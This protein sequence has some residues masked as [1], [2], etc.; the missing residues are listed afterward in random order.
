MDTSM[1]KMQRKLYIKLYDRM[2]KD[3]VNEII[4]GNIILDPDYQRN[5][6]WNNNK[7]SLLIESVLLNIPI[8][9]IYA[10][11]DSSDKW[12][13]VD[14]LQRLYS[15]Q[16]YFNN[17][18]KLVGLETLPELNGLKF[19]KLDESIQKR[20][21][22]GE[23]R[24]IVLQ[25]DSDPNIQFDIFM[26]LNTGAVKL[27][28]QELRN[29]LYRGA[30]NSLI[31]QIVKDN[32]AVV[33]MIP[34]KTDRMLANELI[35]RYLAVSEHYNKTKH[36]IENYDG[37]I[38]NL[39]NGYMKEHQ[40]DSNDMLEIIRKKFEIQIEK[41]YSVLGANGFKKN[42]KTTKLNAS[43]YECIMIGFEDYSLN[44]LLGK[45]DNI[46]AM[47]GRLLNDSKFLFSI[48]KATGNTEI[49]NN[50]L[51]RFITELKEVMLNAI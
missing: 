50:R 1:D 48:D 8:P 41:A 33:K 13:I 26:R 14:G 31:K 18:F 47:V 32:N 40:N 3:L 19:S 42:G 44:D 27:N 38:K 2:I 4:D 34:S 37:R 45:K 11:E 23:L 51:L 7:A 43:L 29:C 9:V 25:N 49:I 35:L 6:V 10:S 36:K 22:R 30:L 20:L 17:E 16:R 24:L 39:I 46:K 21:E 15:L 12:I 28:E 5:Y